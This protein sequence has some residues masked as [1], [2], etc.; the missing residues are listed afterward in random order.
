MTLVRWKKTRDYLLSSDSLVELTQEHQP[1]RERISLP[2]TL[3][4]Q[5]SKEDRALKNQQSEGEDS[6]LA[7]T[8]KSKLVIINVNPIILMSQRI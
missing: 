3:T 8:I 1:P 7:G 6:I 4:P 2:V 5:N